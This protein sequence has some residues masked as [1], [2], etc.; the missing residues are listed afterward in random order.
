[1]LRVTFLVMAFVQQF[2]PPVNLPRSCQFPR[3]RILR[4]FPLGRN[5]WWRLAWGRC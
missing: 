3:R 4:S 2:D 5:W 1:M